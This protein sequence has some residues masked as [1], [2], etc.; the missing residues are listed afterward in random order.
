MQQY[1]EALFQWKKQWIRGFFQ[2][3]PQTP[4]RWCRHLVTAV[5][6]IPTS[7]VLLG[8]QGLRQ[9]LIGI[10]EVGVQPPGR[11]VVS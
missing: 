8:G 6:A 3:I 9:E 5:L 10:G 11:W 2:G 7:S 1:L 4:P